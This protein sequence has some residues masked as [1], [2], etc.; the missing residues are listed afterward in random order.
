MSM[1]IFLILSVVLVWTEDF[2]KKSIPVDS[3]QKRKHFKEN[4]GY[5]RH[6]HTVSG[7]W[8]GDV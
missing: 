4:T 7:G 6:F 2:M 3:G 1:F 5:G 8:Y